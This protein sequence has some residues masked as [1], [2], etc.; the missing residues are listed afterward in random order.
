[1][2]TP[3]FPIQDPPREGASLCHKFMLCCKFLIYGLEGQ[4]EVFCQGDTRKQLLN[5]FGCGMEIS[6]P[7]DNG[8]VGRNMSGNHGVASFG[9]TVTVKA[10]NFSNQEVGWWLGLKF[11]GMKTVNL[12]AS[13]LDHTGKI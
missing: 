10:M 12:S 7:L 3:T 2:A 4:R 6:L 11:S 1:M 13:N 8:G 9:P 5:N